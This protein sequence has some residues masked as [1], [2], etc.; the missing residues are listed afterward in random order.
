MASKR[1]ADRPVSGVWDFF[2]ALSDNSPIVECT[3]SMCSAPKGRRVSRGKVDKP[4]KT[5]SLKALWEHLKTY[6]PDE[7][8]KALA[9]KEETLQKKKKADQERAEQLKIYSV[10]RSQ[11]SSGNQPTLQELK[12]RALKWS[13]E[14]PSQKKGE[15]LVINWICDAVLPYSTVK[16]D[17]FQELMTSL[18]PKFTIPSEKELRQT[19]IPN[20][21]FKLQY[22]I[23]IELHGELEVKDN[24]THLPFCPTTDIWSSKARDSFMSV[25]LH[26]VTR[27]FERKMAVIRAIPYNEKRTHDSIRDSI[28]SIL[29]D[30]GLGRPVAILRDSA[31]NVTKAFLE[32]F[33]IAC[34]C[35]TLQLVVKHSV[36]VQ[37][38]F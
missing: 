36:L 12:D 16:N 34:L 29:D 17:R 4:K 35:H 14:H 32:W 15:K 2:K 5:W 25:T 3:V 30:W 38:G 33:G 28:F 6:H 24:G 31:A 1:P 22:K 20:L 9:T 7:H 27:D 23:K 11:G 18:Q 10:T 37:V 26:Y 8:K 13:K 19:K 21:Y